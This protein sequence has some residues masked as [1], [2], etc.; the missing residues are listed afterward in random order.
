M[1]PASDTAPP[2]PTARRKPLAQT[3][4][5]P[6][7]T[8]PTQAA[9]TTGAEQAT[10]PPRSAQA[11]R[12]CRF[13]PRS[14]R[15]KLLLWLVSLHLGAAVFAAVFSYFSYGRMVHAFM[16]DQMQ[17]L[18]DSYANQ[19]G[20]PVLHQAVE[21][22]VF[23]W[24][25]FLVQAWDADGR[26]LASSWPGL[27]VPLQAQPGWHD[28]RTG[29]RDADTW[30]VYA[31]TPGTSAASPRIQVVQSGSF[32]HD[33]ITRKAL[34]A[35]LPVAIVLPISLL[36]LWAVVWSTSRSLREVADDVVTQDER[37][38][39]EIS[40]TRVPDEIA[41]L[42]V[43]FNSLLSR[44]RDA[45]ATQR[46]FVQDAAH[47]LRTPVTAIGLQLENLRAHVS[48]GAGSECFAQL[49]AGVSRAQHLI[50]QLLRL[51]RQEMP[52]A[53][54]QAGCTDIAML[55]QT[56]LEQAMPLADSRRIDLGFERR[57]SA[58]VEAPA[59]ELRSIFD[60]LIDNALR[61]SPEGAVVDVRLH[62]IEGRPVVDVVDAG[63]GVPT[64]LKARVFDRFFRIPGTTAA[65]SGLGLAIARTAAEQHG[66]HIELL[67]RK[68]S[69]GGGLVA[70]VHL[71]A[72]RFTPAVAPR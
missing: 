38:L 9:R 57:A 7:P 66:M 61:Y 13:C 63:P 69:E 33:Q 28:V 20:T 71:G 29:P 12:S 53:N 32:R 2:A 51:S 47:E 46:R 55:L 3:P 43:A 56:C 6:A 10:Q 36:V 40:P 23:D 34:F 54:E 22:S 44:L 26:L 72:S 49:E 4:S 59:D 25:A 37:R 17:L 39:S 1:I 19:Q 14:I 67:D 42:V 16:D 15:G 60:N 41:P 68:R 21:D 62:P 65:G 35:G 48:P 64:E 30:R 18:A 58:V 70:R 50:G 31:A 24:G 5:R 52:A 27:T 45:F 11:A 8:P